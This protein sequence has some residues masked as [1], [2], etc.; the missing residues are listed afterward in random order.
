MSRTKLFRDLIAQTQND[1]IAFNLFLVSCGG[2][3][4][5]LLEAADYK[6][7]DFDNFVN[8]AT[9]F[10]PNVKCHWERKNG[11]DGLPDRL[12]V[13]NQKNVSFKDVKIALVNENTLGALLGFQCQG[14]WVGGRYTARIIGKY[15]DHEAF[16]HQEACRDIPYTPQQFTGELAH[17]QKVALRDMQF[18]LILEDSGFNFDEFL[19][20][21]KQSSVHTLFKYKQSLRNWLQNVLIDSETSIMYRALF[22]NTD[23][24][25]KFKLF[26]DKYK[27]MIIVLA[28]LDEQ[29]FMLKPEKQQKFQENIERLLNEYLIA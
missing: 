27:T 2:R 20:F 29:A 28:I 18:E 9:N 7:K 22:D 8:V 6:H 12:L 17:M 16:V 21:V 1:E 15:K 26:W 19:P 5:T 3:K 4:A 13:V 14:E 24:F 10:L 23:T 25:R 11:K